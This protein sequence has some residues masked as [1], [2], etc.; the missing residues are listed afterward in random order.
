MTYDELDYL[1][2][3][4]AKKIGYGY[5]FSGKK[6]E[7]ILKTFGAEIIIKE[8]NI[9]DKR[10]YEFHENGYKI[11]LEGYTGPLRD[12]HSRA[13]SIFYYLKYKG[14]NKIIRFGDKEM[15]YALFFTQCFLL[16]KKLFLKKVKEFNSDERQLKHYFQC[17]HPNNAVKDRIEFLSNY[18]RFYTFTKDNKQYQCNKVWRGIEPTEIS[19]V[20]KIDIL[21]E[22]TGKLFGEFTCNEE[23][24]SYCLDEFEIEKL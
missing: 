14:Q 12:E 5:K 18:N 13:L 3:K 6:I 19:R 10:L 7:K 16:P 23:E 2:G 17:Y 9:H 20:K 1:S 15:R 4:V 22:P 11:Y 8:Y 21:N 24:K